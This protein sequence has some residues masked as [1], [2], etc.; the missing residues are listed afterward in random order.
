MKL[1]TIKMR[2]LSAGFEPGLMWLDTVQALPHSTA[3][4]THFCPAVPK[5]IQLS[6]R[7]I[8]F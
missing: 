4:T 8:P 6:F 1:V 5:G 3:K 2:D 7:F